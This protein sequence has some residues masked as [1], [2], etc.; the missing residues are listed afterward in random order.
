MRGAIKYFGSSNSSIPTGGNP[1]LDIIQVGSIGVTTTDLMPLWTWYEHTRCAFIIDAAELNKAGEIQAIEFAISGPPFP[2]SHNS[3][4]HRIWVMHWTDTN[5]SGRYEFTNG[6]IQTDLVTYYQPTDYQ[7]TFG[8]GVG[9]TVTLAMGRTDP[10]WVKLDF[11]GTNL[12]KLQYNGTDALGI[13][14][15]TNQQGSGI[16]SQSN[17]VDFYTSTNGSQAS[18]RGS[19]AYKYTSYPSTMTRVDYRPVM[20]VHIFG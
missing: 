4:R 1:T 16:T 10:T 20:K 7:N 19:Y 9:D 11:G 6:T 14:Y 18:K 17:S 5:N 8:P 13:F 15:Q 3:P 12:T 2:T